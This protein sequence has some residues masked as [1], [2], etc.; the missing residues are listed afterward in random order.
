[1]YCKVSPASEDAHVWRAATILRDMALDEIDQ[2]VLDDAA[3]RL[4][5]SA[6]TS[7]INRNFLTPV[8]SVLHYA[9]RRGMCPWLRIQKRTEPRGRVRWATPEE[10][11][12]LIHA[13]PDRLRP[14]V[15][16]LF[17]TG[18]RLGEALRLDW[19]DVDLGARH[20]VLRDTKNRETYGVYM[21]ERAFHELAKLS[22]REG[23]V[24]GYVNRWGVYRDWAGTCE[25]AKITDFTPHDCRH[26]YATWLRKFGGRD[27][28]A[29]MD[30]GRWKDYKSVVRYAHVSSDEQKEAIDGLP[31]GAKSVQKRKSG[32]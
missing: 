14:L 22:R 31:I 1:M 7:T 17:V 10:A 6:A 13:S 27:L 32:G 3:E 29:L 5:P 16:F 9:A 23:P 25:K 8:A 12:A 26:T 30:L 19:T 2:A 18:A 20:I 24:F 28:K 15:V 4:Y 21:H 11:E